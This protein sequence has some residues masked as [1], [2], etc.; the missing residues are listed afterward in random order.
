MGLLAW[1][2][3]A[4]AQEWGWLGGIATLCGLWLAFSGGLADEVTN[5]AAVIATGVFVCSLWARPGPLFP[6]AVLAVAVALAAVTLWCAVLGISWG[7]I[8]LA[9]T[10]DWWAVARTLSSRAAR[11]KAPRETMQLIDGIADAAT[12]LAQLFPGRLFVSGLLGLVLAAVWQGR[13]ARQAPAL[14]FPRFR[15][16]R[17]S[18]Q[19]VWF[20]IAAIGVLLVPLPQAGSAGSPLGDF[21]AAQAE[22]ASRLAANLLEVCI[23][24]YAARGAA[25]VASFTRLR[26]ALIFLVIGVVFLLP[27]VVVGLASLGLA[28]VWVDFRTR[29]AAARAGSGPDRK[30]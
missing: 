26:T 21:F 9:L 16:F 20:L 14:R 3:P 25:V 13:I 12:P 5:A 18:D 7:E 19:L 10:R 2:R 1:S 30:P 8:E 22:I 17:F 23:A 27:F 15:D 4:S 24:L 29:L 28:D 6:R 11:A